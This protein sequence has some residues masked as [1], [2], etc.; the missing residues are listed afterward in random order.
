[1]SRLPSK[2]LMALLLNAALATPS[3]YV[4]S[5]LAKEGDFCQTEA[6]CKPC[7]HHDGDKDQSC[8]ATVHGKRIDDGDS[9]G[10]RYAPALNHERELT[11][12]T[13]VMSDADASF[14]Q[15]IQPEQQYETVE[16]SI[17]TPT[18]EQAVNPLFVS[19]DGALTDQLKQNL[20]V[21]VAKFKGKENLKISVIG[22]TD[23]QRLSARAKKIYQDNDGLGL[24]RAKNTADYL[25]QALDLDVNSVTMSTMADRE[26]VA[27]NDN[28][29]GMAQNRR[30]E[31]K[32]SYDEVTKTTAQVALP[33]APVKVV[34]QEPLKSCDAVLASRT[35][36]GSQPFRISVDGV[37][38]EDTGTIDPDVQRCTDVALEKSD[39]QVR[40]DAMDEKPSLNLVAFPNAA[41]RSQKVTFTS[42]SN[43]RHW[44]TR[45]EVRLFSTD[46]STQSAPLAVL[47]IDASGKVDWIVTSKLEQVQYVLRVYDQAG[48]FDETIP[49]PLQIAE[50]PALLADRQSDARENLIGYGENRLKLHNIPVRN[51]GAITVNG[52]HLQQG[53]KVRFLGEEVP[54]DKNGKFAARQILPAGNHV[55]NVQVLEESGTETMTF[56]RNLYIPDQD[57]FYIALAD[58]T[59]GRN[60][61]SGPAQLVTGDTQH[62]DNEAYVDGRLAFYLKGKVKGDWLLTASADTKEQPIKHLFSNIDD[63]DPRYLLRRLDPDRY[64][65]VYGDDS[66]SVEDAPTRGKF[67]VKLARGESH[68][69]WGN[70]QTQLS[71]SDLVQYSRG[72]YGANLKLRSDTATGFGQKN[73][74]VDAF[75]GDPGTLGAREQFRGTGGSLYYVQ[76]QDTTRGSDRVWVEVR[77]KDSGI[78][79]KTTQLSATQDYDFDP[80]QGRILLTAP[81]P[82]TADDSQLVRA[83]SLSGNPVFLMVSYEY[84]PSIRDVNNMTVGGHVSQWLGDKVQIGATG[85]RQGDQ[86]TRQHIY[87]IDATYRVSA[88]VYLKA[89]TARSSGTGT[90]TQSSG[91][92]GFEFNSITSQGGNANAHRV[93]FAADLS[94]ISSVKGKVNA[95]WQDREKGFSSPGQI[96]NENSQQAGFAADIAITE[97]TSVQAKTDVKNADMQDSQAVQASVKHRFTPNWA[98][99]VGV[100]IDNLDTYVANASKTLSQNGDRTD[101]GVQLDYQPD[102]EH[103]N[104]DWNAYGFLQNTVSNSGNRLDN[105]RI[106]AGGKWR[107]NEK[108]SLLGEA[109]SGN[110]GFGGKLGGDWQVTDRSQLYLNYALDSDRTDSLYRGRQGTLVTGAKSRYTDS[111]SV[112]G[113]ERLL[114]GTGQSG[115]MHA[116]GLDLA[117]QDGWNFGAKAENGKLTDAVSGDLERTA[118]SFSVGRAIEKTKYAG[119]IEWRKDD[120]STSGNRTT[121]LVRNSLSYQTTHDWRALGKLNF[122]VSDSSLGQSY[123][124]DFV[125]GVV[126]YAYRPV[127]NDKLNALFKYTYFMNQPSPGALSTAG[128]ASDYEQRS[129]ILSVDAVYDLKPWLSVGGKYGYRKSEIR[130]PKAT[131]DW[132]N[133]DAHLLVARADW[134]FVHDWDALLEVRMLDVP[135]ADDSRAG[136]LVGVYRHINNNVK[137]GG[138]FNFTDFSDDM[139][140]M[141]Y[142]SHGWFVNLISKL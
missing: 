79:L 83:G 14:T 132:V 77:D 63:K 31:V 43:Y 75:V 1:M 6:D 110:R 81:L 115:L 12:E 30:I 41:V 27:S 142:R 104:P 69:M 128:V 26:P 84:T 11:T 107:L 78:V 116:F 82:S 90:T 23:N 121:W 3:V 66:T 56:N 86:A 125:E 18:T 98:G 118:L 24:A 50:K 95:Y 39:I 28:L 94:E 99:S 33:L 91:T 17:R 64:Y 87:G 36:A 96:T 108:F 34:V 127:N 139:T 103:E 7:E 38:L 89:E 114:H 51:G 138:G 133:A 9:L 113:E 54:V 61:T 13:F 42:Y 135:A 140:D 72:M 93:E 46:A 65:P 32:V 40:Y 129:Q 16:K 21:L 80:I 141:S 48:N 88:G 123:D 136:A 57:W 2:S 62:F 35:R 70:F 22:H 53:Q 25:A 59:A 71:G 19:G 74:Q 102:G 112:Y 100:R 122:S 73:T 47:P 126:G 8:S 85:Y 76:H 134:H 120:S 4:T 130:A 58:I 37:P 111:L 106:G 52:K 109:S 124:A 10:A 131:G 60:S 92:G 105:D 15:K 137:L 68:V 20:D 119:N 67:Y 101:L 97:A 29:Q 49:Q 55:V 45:S 5:A 117:A 44:I